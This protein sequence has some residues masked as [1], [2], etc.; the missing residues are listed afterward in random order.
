MSL[1]FGPALDLNIG[2]RADSISLYVTKDKF[3]FNRVLVDVAIALSKTFFRS[4]IRS[5][6]DR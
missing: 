6:I 3:A 2:K 4:T 1:D 5:T